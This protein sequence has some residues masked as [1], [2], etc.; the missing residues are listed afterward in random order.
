M[1]AEQK[2][3]KNE[4]G[5][6]AHGLLHRAFSQAAARHPDHIAVVDSAASI[7]YRDLEHRADRIAR[8]LAASTQAGGANIGI[9][10]DRGID[11]I[12][13]IL[14]VLKAGGTYVPL[15]PTFPAERLK[16]LVADSAMSAI[17]S[18]SAIAAIDAMESVQIVNI[19][20]VDEGETAALADGG[21]AAGD[22]GERPAYMIYTSGSTG[23]PK[24]VVVSHRN[25]LRLMDSTAPLFGFSQHD[26][27][28]L[29]H[30]VGF[31][32]SVWEMWGALLT[33]AKLVVVPYPTSRS[34]E[35]FRALLDDTGVTILNTTA[36]AFRN[37]IPVCLKRGALPLLRTVIFGGEKLELAMLQPW[38]RAFGDGTALVNMYGITEATVHATYK[39]L[40]VADIE[41]RV[42]SP[43]GVP[44]RDLKIHVLDESRMPVKAGET[45]EMYIEGG[46]VALGYYKRPDLTAERFL[47]LAMTEGGQP[48][49]VYKTGDLVRLEPDGAM[50]YLARADSQMKVRG[51]RVEPG[52]IEACLD[53]HPAVAASVVNVFDYGNG[54]ERLVAFYVAAEGAGAAGLT[55]QL[56]TALQKELPAHMQPSEFVQIDALPINGNGKLDRRLLTRPEKKMQVSSN[57]QFDCLAKVYGIVTETIGIDSM[58]K[59]DD[60][61]DVGG[62]SLTLVRVL[63][64]I[65]EQFDVKMKMALLADGVS[66]E[67]L[68]N[69]ILQLKQN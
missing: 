18:H 28:S 52:E 65:N 51:F 37:L 5:F 27:W 29:F 30:S 33:G 17:V 23:L 10:L 25:V 39:R 2:N 48:V 41:D 31:D 20:T 46:G 11:M 22:A 13:A 35:E 56:K 6:C 50:T 8:R 1:F 42:D 43:I 19:D 47:D 59:D 7:S 14:G 61:F 55:R 9:Y 49:R 40:S 68:A 53:R 67:S 4:T 21:Q 45:G 64:R 54:D 3:L 26:T 58:S 69:A 60:F 38:I 16:Y 36:S 62:T 34:P 57:T 66:I 44:L 15:D 24:G 63:A 12:A 32:F